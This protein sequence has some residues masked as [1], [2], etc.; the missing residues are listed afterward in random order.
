MRI[1][2][3]ETKQGHPVPKSAHHPRGPFPP[4]MLKTPE[5]ITEYQPLDDEIPV[6]ATAQNNYTEP[7]RFI[8]KFCEE[9]VYQH[10]IPDHKCDGI[11]NG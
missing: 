7:K 2:R 6:G 5:V 8:C 3:I 11:N 4:E 9:M 1:Q 10:Q